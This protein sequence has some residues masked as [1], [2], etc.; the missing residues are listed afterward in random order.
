M[1]V[2]GMVFNQVS[3]THEDWH[4]SHVSG[5]V[6]LLL[7]PMIA[8]LAL[9]PLAAVA[10]AFVAQSLFVG[11]VTPRCS[12]SSLPEFVSPCDQVPGRVTAT[13]GT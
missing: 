1:S 3:Q 7:I 9:P 12:C 5:V 11:Y 13:A 6:G 8:V 4:A 10:A 2:I